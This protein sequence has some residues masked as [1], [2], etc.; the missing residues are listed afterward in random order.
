MQPLTDEQIWGD[1]I[2]ERFSTCDVARCGQCCW[3]VADER[4]PS[5]GYCIGQAAP[6]KGHDWPR[7]AAMSRACARFR[8]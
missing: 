8:K 2:D 1:P 6:R 3:Y 7:Y 4:D 5:E